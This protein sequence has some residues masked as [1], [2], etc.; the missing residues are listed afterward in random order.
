MNLSNK[1]NK[2][3]SE[4]KHGYVVLTQGKTWLAKI[5]LWATNSKVSHGEVIFD[6]M[7]SKMSLGMWL[8]AEPNYLSYLIRKC[9]NFCVIKINKP[10]EEINNALV[11]ITSAEE[12]RRYEVIALPILLFI[13]KL[14]N[15]KITRPIKKA[16]NK[17]FDSD[18][19]YCTELT[20]KYL[21]EKLNLWTFQLKEG[22][23]P[24]PAWTYE[25]AKTCSNGE[26]EIL[27]DDF[28]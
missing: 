3:R 1:Y 27:F 2:V 4:C 11:S 15:N 25:K 16:L 21:F 19:D 5:I 12:G 14:P 13:Y 8:M 28:N 7:N 26:V 10:T 9:N 17:M 6:C 22:E 18:K 24:T 20:H 23:N